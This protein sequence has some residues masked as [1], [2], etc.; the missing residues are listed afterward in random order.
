MRK[1]VLFFSLLL[2]QVCLVSRGHATPFIADGT[3]RLH[4]HPDGGAA[5]GP[6]FTD[7]YGLRLDELVDVTGSHD[8]FTFDFDGPGSAMFLTYDSS[9][10]TM[11]TI[12][13]H[14]VAYGGLDVGTTY[15]S[16]TQAGAEYTGLYD[17]NFT[18]T[19]NIDNSSMSEIKVT[20]EDQINN[21]GTITFQDNI[22]ANGM[23]DTFTTNLVDEDGDTKG[24]S[25]KLTTGWRLGEHPDW[26]YTTTGHGWLNLGGPEHTA[27]QDW[28]FT[29]ESTPI[30]EPSTILLLGTGMI[31]LAAHRRRKAA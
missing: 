1:Y 3:Y 7:I 8:I 23:D 16:G 20:A 21:T 2:F 30:P 26:P 17:V 4:S 25:F 15:A 27:A 10:P 29:M 12:Q 19:S 5:S 9:S 11:P 22:N 18:Y 31:G 14:G 13:I 6:L 28:L 24:F